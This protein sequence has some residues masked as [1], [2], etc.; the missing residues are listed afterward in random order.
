M[1]RGVDAVAIPKDD[2]ER[3]GTS[4]S[5]LSNFSDVGGKCF[6]TEQVLYYIEIFSSGL[7][8][9]PLAGFVIG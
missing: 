4:T 6:L 8:A 9:A 2:T 1:K 7:W 3:P 5:S